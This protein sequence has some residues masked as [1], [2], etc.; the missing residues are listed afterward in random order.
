MR[1][2]TCAYLI[3]R[4]DRAVHDGD[5]MTL[6]RVGELLASRIGDPLAERLVRLAR[7]GTHAREWASLRRAICDRI[8]IAGT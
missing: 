6:A 4:G 5:S 3:E 8:E 1:H 2:V 7:P